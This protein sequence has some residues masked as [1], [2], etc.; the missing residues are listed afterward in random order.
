MEKLT[1]PVHHQAPTQVAP[2]T[3]EVHEVQHALGAPMSVYLNSMVIKGEQP[4]LVDTGTA[5]NRRAW[6]EDTFSLVD[7]GDVRWVFLSHDD[8][9]HTGNLAEVMELCPQATLVCSWA[10]NERHH[11]A[12]EF[13]LERCRWADDGCTIEA[14]DRSLVVLRPP[15]YDS[16]TSRGLFDTST[17]VYWAVDAFA[18]PVPGGEGST[19]LASDVEQLDAEF[20][21]HGMVMFGLNALSPWLSMVDPARFAA[22]VDRVRSHGM[23]TIVSAHSPT[24]TGGKV[25]EAWALLTSLAGAEAPP[26]PDQ[27]ALDMIIAATQG[28]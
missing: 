13:P 7:P 17:G 6:L 11:N 24:I 18:T 10:I 27:A 15:A 26:A 19:E 22:D 1:E 12:F 23:T 21:Q 9:D 5:R 8:A 3:Y 25:A 2:G 4:V 16:P 14:G 28:A 20:W